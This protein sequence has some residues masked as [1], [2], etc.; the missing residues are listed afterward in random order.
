MSNW[1]VGWCNNTSSTAHACQ[2][3]LQSRSNTQVEAD[4]TQQ[5]KVTPAIAKDQAHDL[6]PSVIVFSPVCP[7]VNIPLLQFKK[8]KLIFVCKGKSELSSIF[9]L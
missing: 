5:V 1:Y 2:K 3:I 6:S 7:F 4:W 9:I 8:Y